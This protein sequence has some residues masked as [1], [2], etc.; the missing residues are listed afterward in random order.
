[1]LI[2]ILAQAGQSNTIQIAPQDKALIHLLLI[3]A[4]LGIGLLMVIGLVA[5]WRNYIQRQREIEQDYEDRDADLPRP[6]AW[7]TAGQRITPEDDGPDDPHV[8]PYLSE[9]DD[10]PPDTPRQGEDMGDDEDEDDFPFSDDDDHDDGGPT[11]RA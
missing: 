5:A 1:M 7:A 4:I 9:D 11:G 2:R 6:D 3:V 10:G 8:A